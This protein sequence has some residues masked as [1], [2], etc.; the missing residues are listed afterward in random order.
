[1]RTLTDRYGR[2]H[3]YLRISV[4]DRCNLRCV[5]CMGPDGVEPLSHHDILSYEE[6]LKVVRAAAKL[7]I[8]KIRITGGEPL[9]RKNLPYLVKEI[10]GI[11]GIEDLCLLYTSRCV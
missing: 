7:G 9:V 5:Y 10:N 11:S 6:I 2:K 1:M 4:T 3:D 8:S